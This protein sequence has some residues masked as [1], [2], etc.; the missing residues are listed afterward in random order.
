M[1]KIRVRCVSL[2]LVLTFIFFSITTEAYG[3][4][5]ITVTD[6]M[7][8]ASQSE[9]SVDD[10]GVPEVDE[11]QEEISYAETTDQTPA[12]VTSDTEEK[13]VV[14]DD[15]TVPTE[16]ENPEEA[17]TQEE[18]T[19]PEE[20]TEPES[21]ASTEITQPTEAAASETQ[22]P[23]ELNETADAAVAL[24]QDEKSDEAILS[25]VVKL[26]TAAESAEPGQ[27]SLTATKGVYWFQP[28]VGPNEDLTDTFIYDDAL[29]TGDSLAYNKQLATMS[30][31]MAVASISSLREEGYEKKSRNLRAFLEDNG[32]IDFAVNEDYTTKM[33]NT[34]MG[35]ACAHKQITDN[36]KTYTV[37]VIAPRSAGYEAEWGSNFMMGGSGDHEG[38]DIGKERI[39]EFVQQYVKDYGISG[40]IKVW[41]SGYSRGAGVTD[42]VAAALLRDPTE[43]L[44]DSVTLEPKDLYCYTFGTPGNAGTDGDYTNKRYL[45]VHNTFPLYDIVTAL[46]PKEAG[47]DYYGAYTSLIPETEG[48]K[49]EM[50]RLLKEANPALY[51]TYVN[52]GGDPDGFEAKTIDL[53]ALL[54]GELKWKKADDESY[55]NDY[56]Q[57]KFVQ[58]VLGSSLMDAVGSRE[59]YYENYQEPMVNFATFFLTKISHAGE[60]MG[61]ILESDYAIPAGAAMYMNIVAEKLLKEEVR[62]HNEEL[63]YKYLQD[64][65]EL[66]KK[67]EEL[68]PT[69]IP[70]EYN[71]LKNILRGWASLTF[72]EI[73]LLLARTDILEWTNGIAAFL[74]SKAVE[75][76]LTKA[77]AAEADIERLSSSEDSMAMSRIFAYLLFEDGKQAEREE[78][79]DD[80]NKNMIEHAAT[81]LGNG[82]SYLVPHLNEVVI[83]WLKIQDD[84]YKGVE[85]E[86]AA[87][88]AG[89]RRVYIQQPEG[90]DVTGYVKDG[91]GNVVAVFKN[92][93]LISRTNSWIS[94]TTSDNGNWLR[95]PVDDEY[96]IDF[97][98][99]DDTKLT[100][101]VT[102]YDTYE[103][104]E[105]RKETKDSKLDWQDLLLRPKDKATLVI[106][107]L[108]PIDGIF[109]MNSTVP[110]FIDLLR[111]F[112]VTYLLEGGTLNSQTGSVTMD[113]DDGTSIVFP[114]PTRD[115]YTFLYWQG[116]KFFVGDSL[117]IDKDRV[118][119]A[120]WE[121][122]KDKEEPSDEEESESVPEE[123]DDNTPTGDDGQNEAADA[124]GGAG[125]AP[126]AQHKTAPKTGDSAQVLGYCIALLLS[127]SVMSFTLLL[128]RR[129]STER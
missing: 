128:R 52:G 76:G 50:L 11:P 20:T 117:T 113:V 80:M 92:G 116:S 74:Y 43:A 36:G 35:V 73:Q 7:A 64:A 26:L 59:K 3:D 109:K 58:Q 96:N 100:I 12:G 55:L 119:T 24:E 122:I 72:E 15:I 70:P 22:E 104:K 40:D 79:L 13:P 77:G 62:E 39:L 16:P 118:F 57:A 25:S 69:S 32:F 112:T 102:E 121:K 34:T 81:F 106:S 45:Y 125:Q 28:S 95:L 29:L 127:A 88:I 31:A 65:F 99:S 42:L 56:D 37:L 67:I 75:D 124:E 27:L 4:E 129:R 111:K 33:E 98:I 71:N 9:D 93:E 87:Q 110:Y 97:E 18:T 94:I 120:I 21:Q 51:E 83:S 14:S 82:I 38:F 89:Y 78:D 44:G 49:D 54:S 23:S 107:A 90:V 105:V 5:S 101:V 86:N 60:L 61:P 115:G 19:I 108:Q 114:K 68:D 41:T 91:S 123:T 17:T 66:V 53:E 8:A 84:N 1:R 48:A 30:Y 63:V 46:P 2:L 126:D 47:F 103:H 6:N 85:K 10:I